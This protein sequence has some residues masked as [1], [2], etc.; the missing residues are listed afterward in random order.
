MVVNRVLILFLIGFNRVVVGFYM[1][2]NKVCN[3]AFNRA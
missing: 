3:T 1:V 2:F